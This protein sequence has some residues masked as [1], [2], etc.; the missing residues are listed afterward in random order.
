[1]KIINRRYTIE[2]TAEEVETIAIALDADYD[3]NESAYESFETA[4]QAT[5]KEFFFKKCQNS[6]TL[7]NLFAKLIGIEFTEEGGRKN[8]TE[9]ND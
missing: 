4:G 2:L 5:E 3:F 1:M 6:L 8:G 9:N 7:R